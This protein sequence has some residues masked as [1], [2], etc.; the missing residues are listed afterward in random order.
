VNLE[1]TARLREETL[2]LPSGEDRSVLLAFSGVFGGNLGQKEL[3][4]GR[5][6]CILTLISVKTDGLKSAGFQEGA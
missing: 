4:E 3:L 5:I 2:D 6:R 1:S